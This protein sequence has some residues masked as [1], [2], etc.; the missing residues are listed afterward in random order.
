MGCFFS[1]P[2]SQL[3]PQKPA[4]TRLSS[5][6]AKNFNKRELESQSIRH[7]PKSIPSM[8]SSV[9][10][11]HSPARH[12]T[13][14]KQA[15][16]GPIGRKRANG[17]ELAKGETPEPIHALQASSPLRLLHLQAS[18]SIVG[19]LSHHHFGSTPKSI[20]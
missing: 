15:T 13:S 19:K 5:L 20:T 4:P 9:L 16:P 1:K 3:K 8:T 17:F 12:E 7:A 11:S 14:C 10:K 2:E 6:Q 18:G